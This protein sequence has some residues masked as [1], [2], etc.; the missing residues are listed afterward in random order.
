MKKI[1]LVPK[2]INETGGPGSFQKRLIEGITQKN[3]AYT[4]KLN[5]RKIDAV[6][7]INGTRRFISLLKL[8][9]RGVI[10]VHRLGLSGNVAEIILNET[11]GSRRVDS[12][13]LYRNTWHL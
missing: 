10:I 11:L 2:L 9:L 3:I 6:L 1:L 13:I 12:F 8:K 5:E 4:F 7:L